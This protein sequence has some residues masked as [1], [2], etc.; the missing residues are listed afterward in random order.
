[1]VT[2]ADIDRVIGRELVFNDGFAKWFLE[3]LT[4]ASFSEVRCRAD[5]SFADLGEVDIR[6]EFR[7]DGQ[8]FLVFVEN[9]IDA[10]PTPRQFERYRERVERDRLVGAFDCVLA[11]L[12]AP[13]KYLDDHCESSSC[14]DALVSYESIAAALTGEGKAQL[15]DAIVNAKRGV[16]PDPRRTSWKADYFRIAQAVWRSASPMGPLTQPLGDLMCYRVA[17]RPRCFTEFSI[18]HHVWDE[19]NRSI[20]NTLRLTIN[21]KWRDLRDRVL[22]II[23]TRLAPDLR[24]DYGQGTSNRIYVFSTLAVPHVE[25]TKSADEQVDAIK[26]CVAIARQLHDWVQTLSELHALPDCSGG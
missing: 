11:V 24:I 15:L 7:A 1:M 26:Q 6:A 8:T 10:R 20:H 18:D 12:V 16:P 14:F 17:P 19:R 3:R 22:E 9:K 21:V 23:K 13:T 25:I 5:H 2:E 4:G